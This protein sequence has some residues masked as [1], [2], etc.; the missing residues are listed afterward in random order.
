MKQTVKIVNKSF[1][2]SATVSAEGAPP[3]QLVPSHALS[4]ELGIPLPERQSTTRT[5]RPHRE[6]KGPAWSEWPRRLQMLVVYSVRSGRL[7]I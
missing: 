1:S 2:K 4:S 7:P 5:S 3:L 6:K